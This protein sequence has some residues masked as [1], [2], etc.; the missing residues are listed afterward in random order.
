MRIKGLTP[1]TLAIWLAVPDNAEAVAVLLTSG[2]LK[3][4][5][6]AGVLT[7]LRTHSRDLTK[8]EIGDSPVLPA[9]RD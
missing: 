4:V 9:T 5:E 1:A 8:L 2:D 7:V 6:C 3:L